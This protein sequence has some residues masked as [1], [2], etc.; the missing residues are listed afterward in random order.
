MSIFPSPPF[1]P[2]HLFEDCTKKIRLPQDCA[3]NKL[4]M[5]R[6]GI[7]FEVVLQER[8]GHVSPGHTVSSYLE[9][10]GTP[11]DRGGPFLQQSKRPTC[12]A[13]G[14]ELPYLWGENNLQTFSRQICSVRF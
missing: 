3:K 5:C 1:A 12:R 11:G 10:W 13:M 4:E 14:Q 9:P 2:L 8:K 6:D 7:S